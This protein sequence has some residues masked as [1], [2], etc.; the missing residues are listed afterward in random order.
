LCLKNKKNKDYVENAAWGSFRKKRTL[1]INIKLPLHRK[2]L[3]E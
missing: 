3:N 2:F 1:K